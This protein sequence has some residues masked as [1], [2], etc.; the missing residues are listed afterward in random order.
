MQH[1]L[2]SALRSLRRHPAFTLM[3]VLTLGLGIGATVTVFSVAEAILLRSLPY[4]DDHQ[5]VD[6]SHWTVGNERLM[7]SRLDVPAL[8]LDVPTLWYR[9][10]YPG[11]LPRLQG[12]P[13]ADQQAV[14]PS[15]GGSNYI[16]RWVAA[17]AIGT[18]LLY[19]QGRVATTGG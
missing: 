9:P 10:I 18:K 5:L 11:V 3:A 1:D 2:V 13:A 17:F 16:K 19:N 6:L 14:T 15:P 8:R 7:A 12:V 4:P